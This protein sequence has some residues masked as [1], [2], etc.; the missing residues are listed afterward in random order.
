[1]DCYS[2]STFQT[3]G[4]HYLYD[5]HLCLDLPRLL[6]GFTHCL[7]WTGNLFG[8]ILFMQSTHSLPFL[9]TFS[10]RLYICSSFLFP[11]FLFCL[12]LISFHSSE[13]HITE[14]IKVNFFISV[15]TYTRL[16]VF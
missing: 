7:T 5:I 16:N 10:G 3:L 14:F 2:S 8:F 11:H 6:D 4:T 1:M 9:V 12:S 13:F 15:I